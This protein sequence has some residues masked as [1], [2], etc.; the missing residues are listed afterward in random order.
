LAAGFFNHRGPQGSLVGNI[1]IPTLQMKRPKH[2]E[3]K[4]LL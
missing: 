3:I 1:I 4:F 2:K